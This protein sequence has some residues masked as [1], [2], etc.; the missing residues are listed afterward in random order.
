MN[1]DFEDDELIRAAY[2]VPDLQVS[3]LKRMMGINFL[4]LI[5]EGVWS[6]FSLNQNLKAFLGLKGVWVSSKEE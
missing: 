6:I 4:E 1:L 3:E 2:E 5:M